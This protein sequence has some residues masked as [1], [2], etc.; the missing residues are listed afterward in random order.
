[1]AKGW[2]KCT[3]KTMKIVEKNI[4][5]MWSYNAHVLF[6]KWW[7]V[8]FDENTKRLEITPVWVHLPGLP[9]I[10]WSKEVFMEIGNSLG[11]YYE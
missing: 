8:G 9:L 2:M 4:S 5:H 3:F 7:I 6:L 10:F 11:F 1:M